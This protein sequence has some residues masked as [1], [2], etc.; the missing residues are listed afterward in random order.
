MATIKTE[1]PDFGLGLPV[2]HVKTENLGLGQSVVAPPPPSSSSSM[3]RSIFDIDSPVKPTNESNSWSSLFGDDLSIPASN[4]A[5]SSFVEVKQEKDSFSSKAAAKSQSEV[6]APKASKMSSLFSPQSDT[7]SKPAIRTSSLP[8]PSASNFA[9]SDVKPV[10]K[11][12]LS[13]LHA[14]GDFGRSTAAAPEPKV[15]PQL[16]CSI[17]NV[18]DLDKAHKKEKKHKEKKKKKNKDK[19]K[20]RESEEK[21]KGEEGS[22][23]NSSKRHKN[24]HKEKSKHRDEERPVAEV[25]P[26]P[27]LK[28][29][30]SLPPP[31]SAPPPAPAASLAPSQSIA[32]LKIRLSSD[33]GDSGSKKRPRDS[34]ENGPAPKRVSVDHGGSNSSLNHH[35]HHHQHK[36]SKKVR[37][38]THVAFSFV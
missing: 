34:L 29:K 8:P 21:D 12:E 20:D 27:T 38:F 17:P 14:S 4:L 3:P 33:A 25:A 28:L 30:I 1:K 24:K 6:F 32:P 22:G 31:T 19:D 15:E 11:E 16:L 13:L 7:E 37:R 2:P 35:H 5:Q 23:S 26:K 18:E 36:S 9:A 10:I